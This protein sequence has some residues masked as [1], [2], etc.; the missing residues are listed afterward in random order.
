MRAPGIRVWMAL[1]GTVVASVFLNVL[2]SI[3]LANRAAEAQ[4]VVACDIARTQTDSYRSSPPSTE[5]GRAL[6]VSWENARKR[7]CEE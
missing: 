4:S 6:A 2:I 5:T 1:V 3:N 7:W